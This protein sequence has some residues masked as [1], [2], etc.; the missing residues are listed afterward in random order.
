MSAPNW[1]EPYTVLPEGVAV[2]LKS[3]GPPLWR[4]QLVR[5]LQLVGVALGVLGGAD[6]LNL[7]SVLSPEASKWL[8]V[9]GPAIFASSKPIIM[10]IGDYLDDG[11]K[12]D[13]FKI[14]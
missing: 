3:V 7:V 12:N 2:E 11:E 1:N 10:L 13:S 9:S 14:Q 6:V 4:L 5:V 8:T